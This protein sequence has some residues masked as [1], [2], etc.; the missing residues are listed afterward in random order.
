PLISRA[1]GHTSTSAR[2]ASQPDYADVH[3][4]LAAYLSGG[5]ARPD[6]LIDRLLAGNSDT[7]AIS[8]GVCAAVLGSATTLVQ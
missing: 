1:V 7:R 2:I 8:K 5:G 6:N 3:A 4:E